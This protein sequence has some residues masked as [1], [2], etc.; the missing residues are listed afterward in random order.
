MSTLMKFGAVL[1]LLASLSSCV[2]AKSAIQET[3]GALLLVVTAVFMAGVA[4]VEA[5]ERLRSDLKD[6]SADKTS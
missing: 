6:A 1:C 5:V 4:I 2:V 3:Q